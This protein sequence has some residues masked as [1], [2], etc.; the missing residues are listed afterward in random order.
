MSQRISSFQ[1]GTIFYQSGYGYPT[2]IATRGCTYIDIETGTMYINKDGIVDWVEF[3]GNPFDYIHFNT[4]QTATYNGGDLFWVDEENALSYKPYTINNDVT[5]NIG[6][7]GLIRVFNNLGFQIN[8]GQALHITGTT[9]NKVPTVALANASK[10]GTA[11]TESLAQTSGIATHDIPNN[12]YGFMTNF[13]VVRDFNTSSL[14]QGAEVFLSDTID[15]GLTSDADSIAYTSRISTVGY[16][17]NSDP[18][19]G[20]ILVVINNENPIQSLTQLQTNILLGNT[21]STGIYLY[22]GTTQ[23]TGSTINISPIRGWI[24]YNTYERST[25]PLVINVDYSGGTNIPLTNLSTSDST[26][27]LVNSASTIVQQTTFPTAQQRRE[28]IYLGKVVHPSRV[29]I[30]SI[31]NTVDF[32]VSPM[33]AIRD[34]WSPLK[35]INLGIVISPNGVNM[36]INSSAGTLWGNGIG[37][38]TN[39]LNPNSIT[40]TGQSPVTFQYRT[41]FGPITGGTVPTGNTTTIYPDYY[42]NNGVVTAVGGGSNSSTNQR[43]YL[44]PTGLI[45]IQLGQ[46]VYASLAAAVSASKTETF[47][48]Y[49]LNRDNGIL[50][51]IISVNKNASIPNGGLVDVNYAVFNFVSKFGE[52]MGGTGGLSTTTLQQAYNN[53]SPPEIT[54]NSTLGALTIKNGTGNPDGTTNILESLNA[55]G[56]TTS[57]IRADGAISGTSISSTTYNGGSYTT[58][59]TYGSATINASNN[60]SMIVISGSGTVGGANYVDFIQIT[61]TAVGVTNPNK[62]IRLNNT[63]GIEF[64]NSVYTAST[65]TLGDDG[66]L[67]VGG[68]N[69]A[70]VTSNDASKNYLSFNLNST[71]IYDDGNTHI[72]ARGNGNSMWINTNN[73]GIIIGGQSPVAGGGAAS[74]IIMGSGSTTIKAFANIYGSKTY[75]IGSYGYL[76]TIGAGTGAGTTA[77]YSLYC[78]NRIEA[79]E[80]D[81]TSDERLKDIHGEIELNDAIKLINSLKPI[82]YTWKNSE[83]KGVKTGYSAQQVEK[84]GF[85]HLIGHIPNEDL[86]AITDNE[87]FTSPVGFQLTMNYDQVTP[88]HGVVIKHLLE[89]IEILKSEIAKLKN[90]KN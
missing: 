9:I 41:Q 1:I 46:T 67:F 70:S 38:T 23:G 16:C 36:N 15:G 31:N 80:F 62:T 69:A 51:G 12:N 40:L 81:A 76:A 71:Q 89:E 79:T 32:D 59:G 61:N 86:E 90:N 39:Q 75:T 54:T 24:V 48:E 63:G 47:N 14:I 50:I 57:F 19:N 13:G 37:W 45:R 44:F 22:T 26:F 78:N 33:S 10:L 17:L 49:S 84:A 53:S 7:E 5:V 28:N 35:L 66:A 30:T 85:R 56:S 21:I 88:Y 87:G 27:L 83:D 74:G 25:D 64:L 2:H 34:V 55:A 3:A 77:P 43:V 58:T 4:G 6:Q 18:T 82:K 65:L 11:F 42:D 73:A 29:S 52:I 60:Q 8:N 72:H 20:S 68:G